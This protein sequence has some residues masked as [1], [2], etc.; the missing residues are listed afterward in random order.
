MDM[1]AEKINIK[2]SDWEWSLDIT[3]NIAVIYIY[4]LADRP[5]N[6]IKNQGNLF[7]LLLHAQ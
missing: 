5:T 3:E 6:F 1:R 2:V 4:S 7:A